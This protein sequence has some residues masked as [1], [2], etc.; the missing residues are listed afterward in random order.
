MRTWGTKD[1]FKFLHL[2]NHVKIHGMLC[3]YNYHPLEMYIY[4]KYHPGK[5][6]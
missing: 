4:E 2:D 5:Q 6:L 3:V 1:V